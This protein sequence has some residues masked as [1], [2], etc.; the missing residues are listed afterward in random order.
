MIACYAAWNKSE[1]VLRV[2]TSGG[3]FT[4]LAEKVILAGGV[5]VGAA[6]DE[7]MNVRHE[8][9]DCI[10]GL[11]RLRGVKYVCGM[12]GKGVYHGMRKALDAGRRVMFVGL[13]CQAAAVR[14]MFGNNGSLLICDLVC[15]GAP[16]HIL[17]RKYVDW[18]EKKYGKKLVNVNP[19]DKKY[20]W[21]RKTYYRYD[22][23]DGCVVWKTSLF[24]PYAQ[25]FYMAIAFRTPCYACRFK[26]VNSKADITLCDLWG[27]EKIGLSANVLHNGVSG[28]IVRTECGAKA[29]EL[30]DVCRKEISEE[31][32]TRNNV[33]ILHS[34]ARHPRWEEFSDD[35]KKMDFAGLV[36]KYRL[37][38]TK[39]QFAKRQV[40]AWAST[41]KG[42]IIARI[43]V[44]KSANV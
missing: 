23:A 15:F 10:D 32:L 11:A 13:P 34:S 14:K 7:R 42:W 16:P 6:Y 12:I 38:V 39:F 31:D 21:G 35:L 1:E 5:V 43:K 22:W 26:G 20:G 17:W 25:A 28:V 33:P 2:S 36:H 19:R 9:V 29:F 37:Q 4:A 40:R 3:M 8:I 30:S 24:D 41:L 44:A 18:Q 27:A